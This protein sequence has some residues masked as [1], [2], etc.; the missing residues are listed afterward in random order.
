MRKDLLRAFAIASVAA[1]G[2]GLAMEAHADWSERRLRPTPKGQW[3]YAD[4]SL[5]PAINFIYPKG[6]RYRYLKPEPWTP[7][8][9]AYCTSRWPTFDPNTG[10]IQ[11]PDGVRMCL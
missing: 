6:Q 8:W 2:C 1:F 5:P 9:V 10:T 4:E 11:T 3:F 7:A